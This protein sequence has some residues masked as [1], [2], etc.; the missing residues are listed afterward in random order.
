LLSSLIRY[1]PP[2]GNPGGKS[3]TAL[4]ACNHEGC[5]PEKRSPLGLV[6]STGL[7]VCSSSLWWRRGF[8]CL[9]PFMSQESVVEGWAF[10]CNRTVPAY[11]PHQ[12]AVLTF[13][14]ASFLSTIS[15]FTVPLCSDISPLNLAETII[16]DLFRPEVID[17][18]GRTPLHALQRALNDWQVLPLPR[19]SLMD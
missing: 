2:D 11:T 18:H 17:E 13:D 7:H 16:H 14:S 8:R 10:F 4:W 19:W 15:T 1:C 12:Y 3:A 6:L 9:Q 5:D